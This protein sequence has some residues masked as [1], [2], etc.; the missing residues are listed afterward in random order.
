MRVE[1]TWK[2]DVEVRTLRGCWSRD[3]SLLSRT[4]ASKVLDLPPMYPLVVD[5]REVEMFDSWASTQVLKLVD[6]Y[7]A[8]VVGVREELP[9][10]LA[11]Y[12]LKA[13]MEEALD[14]IVE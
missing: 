7:A 4:A 11:D 3:H 8:L 6:Q 14:E 13:S 1:F 10:D 5:L 2:D 12:P 9:L